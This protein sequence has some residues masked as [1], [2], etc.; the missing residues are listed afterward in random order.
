MRPIDPEAQFLHTIPSALKV[1]LLVCFSNF[2][3]FHFRQLNTVTLE[4]LRQNLTEWNMRRGNDVLAN[5]L[6]LCLADGYSKERT[7]GVRR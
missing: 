3:C 6:R 5:M 1:K 7:F 2:Y 4:C